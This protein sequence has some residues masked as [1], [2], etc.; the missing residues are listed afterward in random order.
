MDENAE[1]A[2]FFP[3]TIVNDNMTIYAVW[4][5]KDSIEEVKVTFRSNAGG[6]EV[7]DMPEAVTVD[8][9]DILGESFPKEEP[10]RDGYIN[11]Q[12]GRASCRERV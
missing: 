10:K 4:K 11:Y 3:H 12:I 8:R 9:G 7:I 1:K 5:K 2:D 6:D